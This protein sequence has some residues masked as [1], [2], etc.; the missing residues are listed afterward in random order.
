MASARAVPATGCVVWCR[1]PVRFVFILLDCITALRV[2][3]CPLKN[4]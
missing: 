1:L 3:W 4:W 2:V